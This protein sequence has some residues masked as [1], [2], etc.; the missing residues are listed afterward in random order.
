M[1]CGWKPPSIGRKQAIL[2]HIRDDWKVAS[3]VDYLRQYTITSGICGMGDCIED[4]QRKQSALDGHRTAH[5]RCPHGDLFLDQK[6]PPRNHDQRARLL[7]EHDK[8]CP[9]SPP[10][11]TKLKGRDILKYID[12]REIGRGIRM[13][14]VN[15]AIPDD[16]LY[17]R[18]QA[19]TMSASR[20]APK[21]D[22][23][24]PRAGGTPL[25]TLSSLNSAGER[26]KM[27]RVGLHGPPPVACLGAHTITASK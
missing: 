15:G 21:N 16:D 19:F 2:H 6:I 27:E 10:D 5:I 11:L 25:L 24:L 14:L 1:R 23:S 17:H 26:V 20:M 8:G 9:G 3:D 4:G 12:L 13:F 7:K 18:D 22:P